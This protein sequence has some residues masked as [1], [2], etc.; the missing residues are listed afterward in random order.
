MYLRNSLTSETKVS[1]RYFQVYTLK[2]KKKKINEE[3]I[4]C[5]GRQHLI[6]LLKEGVVFMS[7]SRLFV[8]QSV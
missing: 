8:A 3:F 6:G 5:V 2:L 1:G 4:I 7:T